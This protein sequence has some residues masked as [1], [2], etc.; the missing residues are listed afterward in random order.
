MVLAGGAAG[1]EPALWRIKVA[2]VVILGDSITSGYGLD[3]AEA[4]PALLGERYKESGKKVEVVNAGVSGDATAGGRRRLAWALGKQGADVLVIALGG[5][6][7]LRGIPPAENEANLRAII[8]QARERQPDV[9]IILAGMQMPDNLGDA[10][11]RA[12]A[13]VYPKVAEEEKVELLPFLL[14]GV[15]GSRR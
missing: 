9:L 4:Y 10:Y 13:A 5:N 1:Q 8:G 6:D 2:R 15:G 14:D 3:V 12:F 11:Q 7:G